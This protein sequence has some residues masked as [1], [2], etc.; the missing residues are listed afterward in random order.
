M[1][2]HAIEIYDT[3]DAMALTKK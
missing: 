3:D 2:V 1:L